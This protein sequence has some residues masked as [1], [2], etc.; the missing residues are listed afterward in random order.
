M[1]KIDF[2]NVNNYVTVWNLC[3]RQLIQELSND[4]FA[5]RR[6]KFR[7]QELDE[8]V[9]LWLVVTI[10]LSGVVMAAWQVHLAYKLANITKEQWLAE[11]AFSAEKWKI[12]LRSSVVGLTIL[13][14]SLAFFIVYVGWIYSYHEAG[15]GLV[16]SDFAPPPSQGKLLPAM[17]GLGESPKGDSAKGGD[18]APVK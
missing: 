15:N 8:R 14:L 5:I 6:E 17:G 18:A 2:S 9:N 13:A 16:V 11:T 7:N 4:D 10:T 1:T 12:S 3:N